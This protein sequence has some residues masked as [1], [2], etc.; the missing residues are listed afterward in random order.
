MAS[1]DTLDIF[2]MLKQELVGLG[3]AGG[4][5]REGYK[6]ADILDPQNNLKEIP[7]AAFAEEPTS[8]RNAAIGVV[9]A[10]GTQGKE[11]VYGCRSLGAPLVFELNGDKVFR[12]RV[13]G[14]EFPSLL[15][16][17]DSESLPGL[18]ERNKDE[19]SPG[20]VLR[21]KSGGTLASQLDFLDLGLLPLLENEVRSKVDS[22]LRDTIKLAI[23]TRKRQS[24]LIDGNHDRLFHLIF[25]L[26]AAK[27][28]A[29]RG[30]LDV[31]LED[32]AQLVL[33][34]F[35]MFCFGQEA[36][37]PLSDTLETKNAVWNRIAHTFHFQNL[38]VDSL[39]YAYENTLVEDE[40]RRQYGIHSTPPAIAEYI[41]KNLPFES[42]NLG[43]RTVFEPF[44]G[45]SI[46]LVAAMQRLRDLLPLDMSPEERHRY[47]V[48]MLS[49]MEI[50]SFAREVARLSL[51]LA[52]F[53]YPDGWRLYEE[54]VFTSPHFDKELTRA[55]IVL[56]NPPFESY[57]T[58]DRKI[59][60][61]FAG[62]RKPKPL[63][64]LKR[65]LEN[66]PRLLGFILPRKF[67]AGRD[68]RILRSDIGS[69]Y[70][71]VEVL[72]LPDNVFQHSESES[73]LLVAS[74]LNGSSVSL[75]TGELYTW[76]PA[77]T[78]EVVPSYQ[79]EEFV[80]DGETA[81][82][83]GLVI[84]EL[85]SVWDETASMARLGD[86]AEIRRG[87]QYK[88][89]FKHSL[90]PLVSRKGGPELAPGVQKVKGFVEPYLVKDTVFLNVSPNATITAIAE[91]PWSEPK[92]LVS[93]SRQ[94]RGPWNI[95][96][97]IDQDGL[98]F[99][100]NFHGVWPSG[101]LPVEVLAAI[102]NG[103]LASAY[104]TMR[105]DKR[106]V[107]AE[108]LKT[109]PVPV[110]DERRISELTKLVNNYRDVRRGWL[111]ATIDATEGYQ[112][113]KALLR[114]IDDVVL[115]SYK[116]TPELKRAI[117]DYFNHVRFRSYSRL[118]PIDSFEIGEPVH[119]HVTDAPVP[120]ETVGHR[121]HRNFN[122]AME[123]L[124][125][126]K[127]DAAEEGWPA[128][129]QVGIGKAEEILRAMYEISPLRYDIY[130][131]DEGEV[132]IDGGNLG[133]RIGVFCYPDGHVLYIGWVD[134]SRQR[135][136][137]ER[138]DDIPHDFLRSALSQLGEV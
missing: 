133:H 39:A 30:Q 74:G 24:E 113:C 82:R 95:T 109:I 68:Y 1:Y 59:Y 33:G 94:S 37:E 41:V 88:E 46:F 138:T 107:R 100:R 25:R 23:D 29:D 87:I 34:A 97:S 19:W 108:T 90:S 56:C 31:S 105:G 47:F 36:P 114:S 16:S 130:P 45:H 57:S 110:F 101:T 102:L 14:E 116:L 2:R 7:L 121:D 43:D 85:K 99:H 49:G 55:N 137:G 131:M 126:V 80:E 81:F 27:V 17:E 76:D 92:I 128:P 40:A 15:G 32:D 54:D 38:S 106:Y 3:Y 70:S 125:R 12:W 28:L 117:E 53:P 119:R 104:V 22:F 123:D 44:S 71:S 35:E 129:S 26:V 127:Q 78:Y 61:A 96:A 118:G 73:A 134:G 72:A 103:P 111:I 8:Y 10:N 112:Q 5:L 13:S 52:D 132:V 120:Q 9:I 69:K 79:H 75:K 77:T 66:P 136:R 122:T 48:E 115:E 50:D 83:N 58:N 86:V 91:I 18:F 135:F 63:E 6:F 11:L 84:S 89:S 64:V 21:A 51:M 93:A 98:R 60:G 42:L 67:V 62:I 124:Q 65:V 4:L 20:Q